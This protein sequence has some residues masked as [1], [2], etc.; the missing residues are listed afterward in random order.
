MNAKKDPPPL[1]FAALHPRHGRAA[2]CRAGGPPSAWLQDTPL[3]QG[4][5]GS[6]PETV[7]ST[8]FRNVPLSGGRARAR[9]PLPVDRRTR[10]ITSPLNMAADLMLFVVAAT[11][12][13]PTIGTMAVFAGGAT[14]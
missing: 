1:A 3:A 8:K 9:Q 10:N 13:Q 11:S 14:L 2:P 5:V 6:P 4:G 7:T 12:L